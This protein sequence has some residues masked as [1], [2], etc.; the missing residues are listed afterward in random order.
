MTT[1]FPLVLNPYQHFFYA[2]WTGI[3]LSRIIC[4]SSPSCEISMVQRLPCWRLPL[5]PERRRQ[6]RSTRPCTSRTAPSCAWPWATSSMVSVDNICNVQDSH[7]PTL[8]QT[9]SWNWRR[10]RSF[11]ARASLRRTVVMLSSSLEGHSD[12]WVQIIRIR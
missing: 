10:E 11:T 6:W 9:T 7:F 4:M 8:S 3:E 12:R 2:V 5:W 1:F